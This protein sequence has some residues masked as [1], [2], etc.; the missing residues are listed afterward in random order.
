[1]LEK[2]LSW[3]ISIFPDLA[4]SKDISKDD[5]TADL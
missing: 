1:M 4:N 3:L 2:F 5:V